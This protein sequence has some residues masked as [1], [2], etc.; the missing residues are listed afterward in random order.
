M[1]TGEKMDNSVRPLERYEGAGKKTQSESSSRSAAS[2]KSTSPESSASQ[3]E[4]K[5]CSWC[6]VVLGKD[7]W[8]DVPE[9]GDLCPICHKTW[10]E[11]TGFKVFGS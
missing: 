5:H 7:H 10:A 2:P 3:P 9:E 4:E 6:L 8:A 1:S 11:R